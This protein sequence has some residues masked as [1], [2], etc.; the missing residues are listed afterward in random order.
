MMTVDMHVDGSKT[1]GVDAHDGKSE[2]GSYTVL[3]LSHA[4]DD[5]MECVT[6]FAEPRQLLQIR[7][8]ITA[9]FGEDKAA[10]AAG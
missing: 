10:E 8:K 3:V 7:D 6:V 5:G 4:V 1:F 9:Y 2:A